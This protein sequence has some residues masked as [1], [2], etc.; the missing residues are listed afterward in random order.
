MSTVLMIVLAIGGTGA[1]AI[2]IARMRAAHRRYR[3][4]WVVECPETEAC[5]DITLD[6]KRAMLTAVS[7]APKL[8]VSHCARWPARHDC[9]QSCLS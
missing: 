1:L 8:R 3:G 9:D 5:T 4:E 7:G 2:A 6:T